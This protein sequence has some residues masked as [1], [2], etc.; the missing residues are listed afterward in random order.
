MKLI[1]PNNDDID[2]KCKAKIAKST[3]GPE[4]DWINDNGGYQ[5]IYFVNQ[6]ITILFGLYLKLINYTLLLL[7]LILQEFLYLFKI[8][9]TWFNLL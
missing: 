8:Y 4:C 2:V 9:C 3:L 1:A 6:Y 5:I 7:L